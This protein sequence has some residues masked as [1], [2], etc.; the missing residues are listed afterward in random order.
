[1]TPEEFKERM[2][3]IKKIEDEE[4]RHIEADELMCKLL[5]AIGYHDGIKI[6]RDMDK[7][8]A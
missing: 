7:M 2:R 5:E 3:L 1:M 8:Y 6:F 4:E